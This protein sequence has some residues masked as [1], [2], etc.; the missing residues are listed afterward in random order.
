MTKADSK[1]VEMNVANE[2]IE[3]KSL[4]RLNDKGP[5]DFFICCASFEERCISS[6]QKMGINFQTKFGV[7]FVVEEPVYKAKIERNMFRL[8]TELRKRVIEGTFVITSPRETTSFI[9]R[10]VDISSGPREAPDVSKGVAG[11]QDGAAKWNFNGDWAAS[12]IMYSTPLIPRTFAISW[13]SATTA[14]VPWGTA[15][16]ANLDGTSIELSM[17]ICPSISAGSR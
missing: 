2:P 9:C 1:G 6:T 13:G 17:C 12:C 15:A 4:P 11:T 3:L 5:D 7:I 16:S 8:Q 10:R 14:P